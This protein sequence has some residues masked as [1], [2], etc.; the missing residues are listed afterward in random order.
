M[1]LPMVE[2]TWKHPVLDLVFEC[3]PR[4]RPA[5]VIAAQTSADGLV[6]P[7]PL[8]GPVADAPVAAAD[9]ASNA[10]AH[11]GLLREAAR[12]RLRSALLGDEEDDRARIDGIV[13]HAAAAELVDPQPAFNG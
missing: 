11:A 1:D 10:A 3:A 12:H 7:Q 8:A 5:T 9:G 13:L 2:H 4:P 6:I